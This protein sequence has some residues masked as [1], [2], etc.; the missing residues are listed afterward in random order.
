M[1]SRAVEQDPAGGRQLEAG[2][3]PQRR[4][5]ARA[6]RAEHREEL[7]VADVEVDA[8]DGDDVAEALRRRLR[9]G[10]RQARRPRASLRG[11]GGLGRERQAGTSKLGPDGRSGGRWVRVAARCGAPARRVKRR[12]TARPVRR[13]IDFAPC[14]PCRRTCR[15]PPCRCAPSTAVP[16]CLIGL[17]SPSPPACEAGA[18]PPTPPIAPG[19]SA[20]PREVNIIAKDYAFLPDAL[21]LV[22]GETVLLHVINGGLEVHE[23]VIGDAAVQ[24]AWEAAEAATVGAP[25]G[26]T[27][28]VSV[29]PDV[30]GLRVVVAPASGSTSSG[31]C[32]PAT[33]DG[34]AWSS[35]ATSPAT[36]SG[37]CRS[38]SGGSAASPASV[39]ALGWYALALRRRRASDRLS[40]EEDPEWPM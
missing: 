30:A 31:R 40:L 16:A 15:S 23:A 8:V 29:P 2:D 6:R 18:P 19:T 14:S 20:A 21:D 5:L 12:R 1:T 28:V 38:R 17:A 34:A 27:P 25:P 10:R 36:G 37:G 35:A 7:A 24:D 9:G 32:P 3:H 13:V 22:P 11:A 33:A 26:P 4:R 39:S